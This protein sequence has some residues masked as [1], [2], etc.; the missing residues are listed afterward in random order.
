MDIISVKRVLAA[1][2]VLCI[3][4][5][6]GL[7]SAQSIAH[8]SHHSH[9]QKATHNTVICSW[10]CAAGLA[11]GTDLLEISSSRL[12]HGLVVLQH[13]VFSQHELR[14]ILHPR[15]PPVFSL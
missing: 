8:D 5:T 7:A 9:H 15:A 1:S 14:S 6:G 11:V 10:M 3:L 12:D 2:L 13:D 4:V